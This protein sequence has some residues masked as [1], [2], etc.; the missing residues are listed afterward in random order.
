MTAWGG[1]LA[2]RVVLGVVL[3]GLAAVA[4]LPSL[5]GGLSWDDRM[6]ISE[7]ARFLDPHPV[8]ELVAG[9]FFG[10]T[11]E[12][13]RYGYYRPVT[14]L[15][16]YLTW[17]WAGTDARPY[18][19]TNLVLHVMVTLMV[20]WFAAVVFPEPRWASWIAAALFA[21]HP[22][23]AEN[24]AWVAGRTDLL[25]AVFTI[26]ALVLAVRYVRGPRRRWMIPA[27]GGLLL[28]AMLSKEMAGVVVPAFLLL[29]L[30]EPGFRRRWLE[31]AGASSV[32]VICVVILRTVVARVHLSSLQWTP[33]QL[34]AV[35]WTAPATFLR[36]LGKL[37]VPHRVEPFMVNPL[38]SSPFD[39]L[40][41]AGTVLA[42]AAMVFAWKRRGHGEGM[43]L[44]FFLASFSLLVNFVRITG[45]MDM[46]A[47]MAE[48]FLYLPSVFFCALAGWVVSRLAGTAA[49]RRILVGVVVVA[50]ILVAVV[51]SRTR[52]TLWGDEEVLFK[53]MVAQQPDAALPHTLLGT[54]FR[55]QHRWVEG[56]RQL[57]LALDLAGGPE[58]RESL[59]ILN[60]LAGC[61]AAQGRYAEA[62]RLLAAARQFGSG[63]D[64][65]EA[66]TGLVELA[67]G[68]RREAVRHLRAALKANPVHR[69]ALLFLGKLL[70]G[71]SPKEAE[72]MLQRYLRRYG[73]DADALVALADAVGRQGRPDEAAGYLNRAAVLR[74]GDPGIELPLGALLLARGR[75]EE[76]G[77]AFQRVLEREPENLRALNGA[78][79]AAARG[80][81]LESARRFL[82]RALSVA[83]DDPDTLLNLALVER[84]AGRNQRAADCAR[85]VARSAPIGSSLHQ[86]AQELLKGLTVGP[87]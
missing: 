17:R 79:I 3:V 87:P 40:V 14:S 82:E 23:H 19:V 7:D 24:V 32:A 63:V 45:P 59:S 11:E 54:L 38:R 51:T 6:L 60:G 9:D 29:A 50:L 61:V 57:R 41:V 76:A 83:P 46:G 72:T 37:F 68:N 69:E 73:E 5:N 12:M 13:F 31:V 70:V 35:L 74:A 86:R 71:N 62:R 52:A 81:Q 18:H 53:K 43:L 25:C 10:K 33:S 48:R 2:R 44:V 28:L 15:S 36:Y 75:P 20:W 22:V 80:H 78:A 8:R 85:R 49:W 4:F 56:E 42:V 77:R 55:R 66:N 39:P 21:V 67:L 47:P 1:T 84:A 34:P 27:A 65:V 30:L 16:Y 64:S 26:P 58:G